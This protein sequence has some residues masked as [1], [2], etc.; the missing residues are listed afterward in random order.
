MPVLVLVRLKHKGAFSAKSTRALAN[1]S[2]TM[3]AVV[4]GFYALLNRIDPSPV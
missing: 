2:K 3:N 4:N 1:H